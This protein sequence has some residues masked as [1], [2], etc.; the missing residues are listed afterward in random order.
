[1]T[2]ILHPGILIGSQDG[3]EASYFCACRAANANYPC[4]KC[5]VHKSELH[6]ITKSF[7]DRTSESMRAVLERASKATSKAAKEKI[8]Q[9]HGL[10]D[11]KVSSWK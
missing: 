11:I 2:R 5:L 4:P 8:L 10:H 1:M 6:C 9:E 3:E 7:K